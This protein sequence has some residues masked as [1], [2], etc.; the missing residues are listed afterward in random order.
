MIAY[1]FF[2]VLALGALLF[3]LDWLTNAKP[4]KVARLIAYMAGGVFI[5]LAVFLIVT[6]R[7]GAVLPV[8]LAAVVSFW[9]APK[10]PFQS[11]AGPQSGAGQRAASSGKMDKAEALDVLGLQKG[12]S[13]DDIKTAHRNLIRKLHPDHGGSSYLAQRINEAKDVLTKDK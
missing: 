6:G 7:G 1:F 5:A 3:A 11:G 10:K 4:F 9:R 13:L 8:L 2:G 12:A